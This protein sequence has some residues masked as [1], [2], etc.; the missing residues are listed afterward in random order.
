MNKKIGFIGAGKMA[1]A[2]I[3]GIIDSEFCKSENISVSDVN[4][5]ALEKMKNDLKITPVSSNNEVVKNSDI[6]FFAVKPFVLK[7]VLSGIKED[8]KGDKL[9]VSIA[10]GVSTSTIE[11]FTGDLPVIRV[12][13][14]TP[15]FVKAGMSA[16]CKGKYA[17]DEHADLICKIFNSLGV[18]VKEEEKN[19]D[20]IT[21]VSGSGPAYFYCF[22]NEFAKAGEKYGL[23]KQTAL[24]LAAQTA[25]GSAKMVME[26]G[27]PV[28]QLIINVTTPGGCTE[29]GNNILA[30]NKI[31]DII[32]EVVKGTMDKAAALGK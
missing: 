25:L 21:A 23:D 13:P 4:S 14:N 31:S 3:K 16:V 10:A 15:A 19:I 29:V 8:L 5:E 30:D 2:I 27:V 12:M 17:K 7:D 26:T 20:V 6:V 22:I 28:E 11:E 1:T 32:D 18:A 9:V 24:T